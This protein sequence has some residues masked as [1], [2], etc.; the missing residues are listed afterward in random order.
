MGF[1]FGQWNGGY[2]FQELRDNV[3]KYIE[4]R[5]SI[6]EFLAEVRKE[7]NTKVFLLTNSGYDYTK[8]LLEYAFGPDWE[9]KVTLSLTTL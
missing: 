2:Y 4:K 9:G 5:C 3:E 8:L 1:N 7:S 6:K